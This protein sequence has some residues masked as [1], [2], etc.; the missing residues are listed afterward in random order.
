MIR[1]VQAPCAYSRLLKAYNVATVGNIYKAGKKYAALTSE[2]GNRNY[3]GVYN[4][5]KEAIE[6]LQTSPRAVLFLETKMRE[7]KP[8][9]V[10]SLAMT[11][12]GTDHLRTQ[13]WYAFNSEKYNY[14]LYR[15]IVDGNVSANIV[16]YGPKKERATFRY[17]YVG[18][19]DK[20]IKLSKF[21]A[22][23]KDLDKLNSPKDDFVPW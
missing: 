16:V 14:E 18:Y 5:E 9:R 15:D 13:E 17:S 12:Q 2:Q 7:H 1:Y 4:T 10:E 6:A 3:Y 23:S 19:P 21:Q 22:I 8:F 11:I 20:P